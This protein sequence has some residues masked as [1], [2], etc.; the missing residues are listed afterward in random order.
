MLFLHY[1]YFFLFLVMGI[2][3][4]KT[5]EAASKKEN[6]GFVHTGIIKRQS[7]IEKKRSGM[8]LSYLWLHNC[9]FK[10]DPVEVFYSHGFQLTYGLGEE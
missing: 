8:L 7:G 1:F 3:D 9:K 4:T 2:S 5:M 10:R 6:F